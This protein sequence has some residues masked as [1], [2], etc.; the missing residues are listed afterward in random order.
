[1]KSHIGS[2]LQESMRV[3]MMVKMVL[4]V[5]IIIMVKI[6]EMLRAMLVSAEMAK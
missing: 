1:M 3:I 2:L 5:M 6:L 4:M